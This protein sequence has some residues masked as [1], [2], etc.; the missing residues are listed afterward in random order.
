MKIL[1]IL[2]IILGCLAGAI[3][4]FVSSGFYNVAATVPHW[5]ITHWFLEEVRDRSISAH[6]KG[7]TV[8][9]L[10]DPNLF[11]I[12]F[13]NYHEMCRLCHGAPGSPRTEIARGLNPEPPDFSAKDAKMRN[14]AELYWV[15]RSGIKMTGMPFFGPTHREDQLW[16]IVALLRQLPKMEPE[17]YNMMVKALGLNDTPTHHDH[18][19]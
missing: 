9:S 2:F 19:K 18:K 7:I 13:K 4:A 5:R 14:E 11:D 3:V 12:G 6:S 17:E 15:I 1:L 10:K 16:G 8:P